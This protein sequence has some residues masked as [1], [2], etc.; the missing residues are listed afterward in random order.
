MTPP[1]YSWSLHFTPADRIGVSGPVVTLVIAEVAEL[2]FTMTPFEL[3]LLLSLCTLATQVV[4]VWFSLLLVWRYQ[5]HWAWQALLLAQGL[6]LYE[7]WT[8]LHW[9]VQS[10]IY[11]D[12][13]GL[14]AL[15]I[16]LLLA[17]AVIGQWR[18]GKQKE[19]GK[20]DAA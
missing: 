9:T 20:T 6:L 18:Q 17:F 15:W 7:R 1:A 19:K 14:T 13:Q 3:T 10:G 2:L 16:S 5:W 8:T 12:K 4:T 11:D